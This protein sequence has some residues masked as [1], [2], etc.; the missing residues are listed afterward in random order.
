[1]PLIAAPRT[2]LVPCSDGTLVSVNLQRWK[3]QTPAHSWQHLAW[4]SVPFCS[5]SASLPWAKNNMTLDRTISSWLRLQHK[6]T[7]ARKFNFKLTLCPLIPAVKEEKK[8]EVN[9][10]HRTS[11]PT[12]SFNEVS[13]SWLF[14]VYVPSLSLFKGLNCSLFF[15]TPLLFKV[16]R[17]ESKVFNGKF[18]NAY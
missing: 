17:R 9:Q 16:K 8:K 11:F 13:I 4:S 10:L 7:K 6:W 3:I 5:P 18:S 14:M 15:L 1:M 2:V 12:L